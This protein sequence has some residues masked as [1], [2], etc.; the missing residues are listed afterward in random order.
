MTEAAVPAP[1]VPAEV[2]LTDFPFMPLEVNRLR[3][4]KGWLICKRKP[5]LAFYMLNLWTACWHD[6]PAGSL[7]DDDDVLA[8]LAMCEPAKW[9]KVRADV[10]RGWVKCS[11]GRLYHPVVCEKVMDAWKAK[12]AQRE[13][14]AK[15]TAAREAKRRAEREGTKHQRG[16]ADDERDVARDDERHDQ[17]D[18]QRDVDATST[19]GEGEGEGQGE[20]GDGAGAGVRAYACEAAPVNSPQPDPDD[21][22]VP[23]D[24]EQWRKWFEDEQGLETD[25]YSHHDRGK[26]CPLAKGWVKAGVTLG[27][28]RKAIQ[29]ARDQAAEPI[30]YLPAYVDVVLAKQ[31]APSRRSVR[32]TGGHTDFETTDYRQGV[33]ED[34]SFT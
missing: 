28:M 14:T 22:C 18:V 32:A 23:S 6:K 9:S 25:P 13:R 33:A 24:W 26:F 21:G 16:S 5:E 7:E 2:S 20:R 29:T 4:S 1:L 17:R 27:Q 30:A 15:A 8:D 3:R 19:K 34:G 11:D 31:S 10:L 12:V